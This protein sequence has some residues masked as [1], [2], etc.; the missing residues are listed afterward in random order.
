M[1]HPALIPLGPVMID[2]EGEV[3]TEDD[4]A[5][6]LHPL[7][8]AVILF[9]KNFNNRL[10]LT[11]LINN[12]KS[13]RSPALLVCVD[14]EGG[15]VQRFR[16]EFTPLPA[17]ARIGEIYDRSS[18]DGLL[19]ASAAGELM[20]AELVKVGVD[21]SF[22]PVLDVRSCNSEVIGDRSFHQD[23]DTVTELAAAYIDGMNSS[24]MS[25]TGKH[26]PGHGGVETDSHRCLPTDTRSLE[27]LRSCDLR[28]FE[29]LAG[30]LGGVMTAHVEFAQVDAKIPTF[31]RYWLQDELRDMLGF[32]GVIFSDDLSM[33]GAKQGDITSCA[34]RA[35]DAGCDMVLVCNAPDTAD[36][37]LAGLARHEVHGTVKKALGARL[38][39]MRAREGQEP[40]VEQARALLR[41]YGLIPGTGIRD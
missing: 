17:A 5:R 40:R 18:R 4:K 13:I 1:T 33:E 19:A 26:F 30:D 34:V 37:L 9:T 20:A 36:E 29:R 16:E 27:E 32:D 7:T 41:E 15:R 8:G 3:L 25:A 35:L 21:F 39:G 12:I 14:Q 24:G 22:A 6:L 10:Q 28:P 23:A 11:E 2:V 31:S 38:G